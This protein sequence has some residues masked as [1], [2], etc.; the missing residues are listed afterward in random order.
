M[1]GVAH[2]TL[3]SLLTVQ[4]LWGSWPKEGAQKN[5]CVLLRLLGISTAIVVP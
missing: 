5:L 1:A 4:S 3:G 2:E